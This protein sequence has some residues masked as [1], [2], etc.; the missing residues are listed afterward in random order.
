MTTGRNCCWI[1][2]PKTFPPG[3]CSCA[4][5]FFLAFL[6][7]YQICIILLSFQNTLLFGLTY[8]MQQNLFVTFCLTPA[9]AGTV[10]LTWTILLTSLPP[11]PT[12]SRLQNPILDSPSTYMPLILI[13]STFS[14]LIL[15][16]H[17]TQ[18]FILQK[19]SFVFC[20]SWRL[21]SHFQYL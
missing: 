6:P 17:S 11:I 7:M 19:Q 4:R 12:L 21:F 10:P 16:S 14:E 3:C 13:Q 20:S 8:S 2:L 5:N 1:P 15:K 18:P 9:F